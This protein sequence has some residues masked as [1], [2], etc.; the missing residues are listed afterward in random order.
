MRSWSRAWPLPLVISLGILGAIIAIPV[1]LIGMLI[2]TRVLSMVAGPVSLWNITW[3]TPPLTE[4]A[5]YYRLSGKGVRGRLP[6]GIVV[7]ERSG[8]RLGADHEVEVVDLPAFDGFG[9]PSN[10][11]YNGTGKW[12]SFEDTGTTLDL[13]ITVSTPAPTGNLPSCPPTHL[14]LFELLGHSPPYRIWYNIGDPDDERGL[15]Y[16][17]QDP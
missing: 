17:H 9:K 11:R 8:F 12:N 10:C 2:G 6:S 15:T 14:G 4:I 16:V 1:L 7:S 5:G 3:H 13:N